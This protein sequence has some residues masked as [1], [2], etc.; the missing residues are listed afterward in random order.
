MMFGE[1]V[2]MPGHCELT[3]T[4]RDMGGVEVPVARVA[5][6]DLLGESKQ[7]D[8]DERV[9]FELAIDL[10]KFVQRVRP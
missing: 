5:F 1:H 9:A 10:L 6:V 3:A 7:L 8:F 4:V 2:P